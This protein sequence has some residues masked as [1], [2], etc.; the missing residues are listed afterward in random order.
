MDG[1][2]PEGAGSGKREHEAVEEG[3]ASVKRPRREA[4]PKDTTESLAAN[5]GGREK[6]RP[7][8]AL[9]AG[10]GKM[11]SVGCIHGLVALL[12]C[13]DVPRIATFQVG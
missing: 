3:L 2:Q 4:L 13:T 10:E 12:A 1:E 6:H 8:H 11:V 5:T 7:L 9:A